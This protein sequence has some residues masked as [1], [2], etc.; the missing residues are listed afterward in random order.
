MLMTHSLM[1]SRMV[2]WEI[3]PVAFIREASLTMLAV[4]GIICFTTNRRQVKM[5]AKD[6][7]VSNASGA[8]FPFM[9]TFLSSLLRG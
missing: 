6:S 5:I 1:F 4:I 9:V 8:D 2:R 7:S 3:A